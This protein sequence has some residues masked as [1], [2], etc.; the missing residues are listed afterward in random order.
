M[1]RICNICDDI[2]SKKNINGYIKF[3]CIFCKRNGCSDCFEKCN[4]CKQNVC[5]ECSIDICP[6][7]K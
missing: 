2:I 1:D 5:S 3:I 7:C 6:C 4:F